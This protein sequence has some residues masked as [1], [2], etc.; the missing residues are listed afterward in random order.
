MHLFLKKVDDL[1]SVLALK[2]GRQRLFTIKRLAVRYIN[3]FIFCSQYYRSKAIR[4][5]RQGGARVVD[6]PVRSFVLAHPG[7]APP[8]H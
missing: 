4:R 8:L 6:L 2:T 1:F 5:A 3:I 7:V